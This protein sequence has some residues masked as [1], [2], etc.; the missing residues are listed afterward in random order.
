MPERH[1]ESVASV[2][3]FWCNA[4]D[5]V[6][7]ELNALW[8]LFK[9]LGQGCAYRYLHGRLYRLEQSRG[10]LAAE[11]VLIAAAQVFGV[12]G[13]FWD[14]AWALQPVDAD[15]ERQADLVEFVWKRVEGYAERSA[16]DA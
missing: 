10:R 8:P 6:Q 13:E 14:Q 15:E 1:R 3:P 4:I 5:A 7:P 9:M 2:P 12:L 11:R 16:A